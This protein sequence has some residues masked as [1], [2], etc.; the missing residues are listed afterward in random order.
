MTNEWIGRAVAGAALVVLSP[1]AVVC[2]LAI[3]IEDGRPVFFR[4]L[5]MGRAGAGFLLL[6]FRSMRRNAP[7][8]RVTAGGD[9][10]ITRAG[11][12]LRRYKLDELPQLWNVLRGEMA[13]VGP[14]PEVPEFVDAQDARWREV[15]RVRPGITDL[16]TLLYRHEEQMLAGA[17]DPERYYREVILPEKLRL[18]LRYLRT[19]SRAS[20]A[21][22]L[23]LTAVYSIFPGSLDPE[24]LAR[25][26]ASEAHS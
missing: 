13:L 12:F 7:G 18:N 9:R 20:D 15:L 11:A 17:A 8:S 23:A 1:L 2:A 19:R 6:K 26:F 10:R 4:Q 21:A 24:R 5:R 16:A 22:L 14:R 25:M 3:V